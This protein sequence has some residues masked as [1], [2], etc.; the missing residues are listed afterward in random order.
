MDTER[1]HLVVESLQMNFNDS[2]VNLVSAIRDLDLEIKP[3]EFCVMAGPNGSGKSTLIKLI[4]GR[5]PIPD[6]GRISLDG[7]DLSGVP[8]YRRAAFITYVSQQAA[9]GTAAGLT[10][11]ENLRVAEMRRGGRSR[12][13]R[14][15]RRVY[16]QQLSVIGLSDR[17]EQPVSTLSG[18]Q[19]Q[20]LTILMSSFGSPS[21]M[22]LD[23]PVSAVDPAYAFMCLSLITDINRSQGMT[24]LM[25]THNFRHVLELG[26]RLIMIKR[27]R[28]EGSY[29][30]S[31]RAGL[32]ETELMS[33]IYG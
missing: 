10:V 33:R 12:S 2:G 15:L 20:M 14:N 23:E 16:R 3:G 19:R 31:E 9:D 25:A 27:G 7:L 1:G 28:I 21:I 29:N 13:A 17:L 24:I 5:I 30:A 6:S 32:N 18:G 11:A 26:D 4:S 22:L 8:E